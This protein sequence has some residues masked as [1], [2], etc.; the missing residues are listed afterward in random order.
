MH[1]LGQVGDAPELGRAC[2]WHRPPLAPVPDTTE[3]PAKTRLAAF[4][5]AEALAQ[6]GV[7]CLARRDPS[8]VRV[9]L[10]HA[11]PV[12]LDHARVRRDVSPSASTS[13][14][15]GTT[16]LAGTLT[17][18][19]WRSHAGVSRQQVL[20][21]LYGLLGAVFPPEGENRR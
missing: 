12:L 11:Q 21:R 8:P 5:L 16:S 14:S 4:E 1:G 17:S 15:P 13:T 9:A 3:V 7:G 19:P 20:Q 18:A 2:R 10:L 6:R